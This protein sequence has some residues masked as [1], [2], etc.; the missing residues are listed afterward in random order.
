MQPTEGIQQT[1]GVARSAPTLRQSAKPCSRDQN[2]PERLCHTDAGPAECSADPGYAAD[3]RPPSPSPSRRQLTAA[4]TSS[5]GTSTSSQ[6]ASTTFNTDLAAVGSALQSGNL[7]TAQSAFATLMQDLGKQRDRN[8][9]QQHSLPGSWLQHQ[10]FRLRP[11]A[12]EG[13]FWGA[14]HYLSKCFFIAGLRLSIAWLCIWQT[15][16]SVTPRV[17]AI[18]FMFISS[19]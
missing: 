2:C 10:Y 7:A 9:R 4:S 11:I 15:R 3:L 1:S 19:W 13:V 12:V 8:L 18:S 6:T 16:A 5:Q 14:G 17:L